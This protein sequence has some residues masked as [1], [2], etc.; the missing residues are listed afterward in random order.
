MPFSLYSCFEPKVRFPRRR[1]VCNRSGGANTN[2]YDHGFHGP[3]CASCLQGFYLGSEGVCKSCVS[4]GPEIIFSFLAKVFMSW[5]V[6]FFVVTYI[7]VRWNGNTPSIL[8]TITSL[9]A[10]FQLLQQMCQLPL[11]WPPAFEKLNTIIDF[12]SFDGYIRILELEIECLVG[13]SKYWRL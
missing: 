3:Q 13:V 2:M 8:I 9:V 11:L 5:A 4:R 12:I 7:Y 1:L 6:V 10:F